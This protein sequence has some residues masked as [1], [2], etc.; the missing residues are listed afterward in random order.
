MPASA[1]RATGEAIRSLWPDQKPAPTSTP[2]RAPKPRPATKARKR[3]RKPDRFTYL[4]PEPEAGH[5][6]ALQHGAELIR[7]LVAECNSGWCPRAHIERWY[8]TAACE[9]RGWKP[10]SWTAIGRALGELGMKKS[11][12]GRPKQVHYWIPTA[13]PLRT[14][15]VVTAQQGCS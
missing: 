10:L 7:I 4:Y 5:R 11:K 1:L 2:G 6:P 8:R 9:E 3:R 13:L 12:R 14:A 15:E